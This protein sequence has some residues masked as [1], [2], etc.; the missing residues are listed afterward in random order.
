M[1]LN[2]VHFSP[3]TVIT[4]FLGKPYQKINFKSHLNSELPCKEGKI[5][6]DLHMSCVV[7]LHFTWLRSLLQWDW[8]VSIKK[9][10][11]V[12]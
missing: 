3:E 6:S 5:L 12:F 7:L 2:E 10:I 1:K 8:K 4:D 9:V 11:E